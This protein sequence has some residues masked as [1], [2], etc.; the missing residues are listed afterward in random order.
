MSDNK[1]LL[2]KYFSIY[3]FYSTT[4]SSINSQQPSLMIPFA[5]GNISKKRVQNALDDVGFGTIAQ[6]DEV[7]RTNEQT[8]K[9][10]KRF[11]IHFTEWNEGWEEL[12]ERLMSNQSEF[13]EVVYDEPWFW[14]IRACDNKYAGGY[15]KENNPSAEKPK[16]KAFIKSSSSK[17]DASAP[18]E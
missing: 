10:S 16:K 1:N 4:M 6:I 13:V 8:G 15:T 3:H 2:R 11:F 9:K 7:S 17:A 12:R 14:K 18:E 5:H